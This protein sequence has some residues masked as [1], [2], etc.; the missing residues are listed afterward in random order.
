MDLLSRRQLL[1]VA[2]VAVAGVGIALGASAPKLLAQ[3]TGQNFDIIT[4]KRFPNPTQDFPTS[5]NSW[6]PSNMPPTTGA[7]FVKQRNDTCMWMICNLDFVPT[8]ARTSFMSM[9]VDG[10]IVLAVAQAGYAGDIQTC[11]MSEI[12]LPVAA[13]T[14][15]CQIY[16]AAEPGSSCTFLTTVCNFTVME[17]TM[18]PRQ[19]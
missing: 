19:T 16:V 12:Y 2:P 8:T 7:G 4:W 11:S 18:P 10:N 3:A 13:G 15:Q 5:S 6:I 17:V 14:H 9:C 1:K